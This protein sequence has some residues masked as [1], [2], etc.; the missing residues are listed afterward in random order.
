[1]GTIRPPSEQDPLR[2]IPLLDRAWKIDSL[3]KLP[4]EELRKWHGNMKAGLDLNENEIT[5]IYYLGGKGHIF[6][7]LPT[8]IY[9]LKGDHRTV[10]TDRADNGDGGF[11][12]N[13]DEKDFV[14]TTLKS[15]IGAADM[16]EANVGKTTKEVVDEIV[17]SQF[18][19]IA[20]WGVERHGIFERTPGNL[21]HNTLNMKTTIRVPLDKFGIGSDNQIEAY[22]FHRIH[23]KEASTEEAYRTGRIFCEYHTHPSGST[24]PSQI[25]IVNM[26]Q[27]LIIAAKQ[28]DG[29]YI[30]T[31]WRTKEGVNVREEL[32]RELS[33]GALEVYQFLPKY[34]MDGLINRTCDRRDFIISE[35]NGRMAFEEM[36]R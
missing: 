4:E 9:D 21:R 36:T 7:I 25:D 8:R 22:F 24:Y 2:S 32:K 29:R 6:R 19:S 3:T 16:L 1:M 26:D 27:S 12:I 5:L 14:I 20:E 17:R 35:E 10:V 23:G 34:R 11:L 33:R 18:E 15:R 30:V 13:L 28:K 31:E